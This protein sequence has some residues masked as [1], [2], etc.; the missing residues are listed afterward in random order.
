MTC[1]SHIARNCTAITPEAAS[2]GNRQGCLPIT[3]SRIQGNDPKKIPAVE[4]VT[5]GIDQDKSNGFIIV[6]TLFPAS[7]I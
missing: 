3:D 6:A 4:E 2:R 1:L 5:A 7:A